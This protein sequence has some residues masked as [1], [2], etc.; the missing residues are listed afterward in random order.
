M[1][2]T[3]FSDGEKLEF[4]FYQNIYTVAKKCPAEAQDGT[5]IRVN[6]DYMD[7]EKVAYMHVW[8]VYGE[9]DLLFRVDYKLNG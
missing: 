8:D 9:D 7:G 4:E 3:N 5:K 6:P 2:V 1:I